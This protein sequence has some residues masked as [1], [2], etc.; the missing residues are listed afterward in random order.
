MLIWSFCG[1]LWS[2]SSSDSGALKSANRHITMCVKTEFRRVHNVRNRIVR[3]KKEDNS[4][5]DYRKTHVEPCDMRRERVSSCRWHGQTVL[6]YIQ[7]MSKRLSSGSRRVQQG[8]PPA[9]GRTY[10]VRIRA[11]I[12]V[13]D[14][15]ELWRRHTYTIPLSRRNPLFLP[16]APFFFSSSLLTH[17]N[18]RGGPRADLFLRCSD[19]LIGFFS[20][21]HS[22]RNNN[23]WRTTHR[24]GGTAARP[25]VS[26]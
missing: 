24:S 26:R 9:A 22:L 20:L 21:F 15:R 11:H 6:C 7:S 5:F 17:Y 10:P 4:F 16:F 12:R 2:D 1:Q 19:R 3:P 18:N 13:C 14:P 8:R 23:N 25:T